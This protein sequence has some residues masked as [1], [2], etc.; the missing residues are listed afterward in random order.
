M[1]GKRTIIVNVAALVGLLGAHFGFD[2]EPAAW[3]AL[4]LPVVNIVLRVMTSTPVWA[5]E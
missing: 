5:K 3:E 1:K 4:V 2:L